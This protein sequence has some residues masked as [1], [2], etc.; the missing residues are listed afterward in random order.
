MHELFEQ[1]VREHPDAIAAVL[2]RPPVDLR[3]AERPREPVGP[4]PAGAGSAPR[5][6]R[7]GGDRA[8]P[9]LDGRR[10]RRSSR[11][12]GCTCPIEPHF[13]ADRIARTLSRAGCQLVLTETGSTATLGQALDAHARRQTLFVDDGLPARTT[14]TATSAST[15][16]PISSPTSTSPP[17]PPVSPRARCAS[18]RAC[19]TTCTPRSTTWR[20]ATGQV[21]AQT[22]PQCFDIS[23]WQLVVRAAGRR[24]DP[25][26]RAGGDPGRRAVRRHDRR[27]PGRRPAGRAVLPRGGAVLSGAASPR[28][29]RTCGACRSPARR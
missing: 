27:R 13:P 11:P 4:G 15:S 18:T 5:G 10:P 2:R 26:R 28:R 20:S 23:L 6:R 16:G 19:S 9:G 22:A 7:G 21:V 24:P 8:Q 25:D 3:R 29:C 1:R 12:A 14:P 17:A